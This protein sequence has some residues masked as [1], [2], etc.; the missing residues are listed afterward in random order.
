MKGQGNKTVKVML[1]WLHTGSWLS[2]N[3][4]HIHGALQFA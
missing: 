3:N 4:I 2:N 1:K